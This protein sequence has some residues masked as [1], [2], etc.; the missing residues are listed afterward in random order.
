MA[1]KFKVNSATVMKEVYGDVESEVRLLAHRIVS[2][3][4]Q[5]PPTGTPVDTGHARSNWLVGI[6]SP[7]GG[8][9]GSKLRVVDNISRSLALIQ[10]WKLSRGDINISN[11]VDYIEKLDD[12]YSKQSP[13][14]FVEK[15]VDEAIRRV[16]L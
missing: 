11:N 5:T 8:P 9:V 4:R 10:S 14:D 7:A 1:V 13:A 6:G 12:G 2:G 3:L 16:G 15:V